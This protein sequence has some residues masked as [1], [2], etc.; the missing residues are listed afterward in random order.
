[1]GTEFRSQLGRVGIFGGTFDPIHN[2]H[3]EVASAALRTHCLGEIIFVPAR[4]QPHKDAR[5]KASA[6]HRLAMIGLAIGGTPAFSV[7]DCEL[8][9]PGK[10]FTI[11]TVRELGQQLGQATEIFF[12]VGSDSVSD[13]PAWRDVREL[14]NLCTLVV[15][16]RPGWPLDSLDALPHHLPAERVAAVKRAAIRSTS[17][18]VSATEVRRRVG[19]GRSIAGLVP[20]AVANYI[21]RNKLYRVT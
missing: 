11:D 4:R 14:S 18:A 16:A 13:L 9:R 3:L 10:S 2:G 7:S 15:A 21:A 20:D 5:P 6:E 1:M 12:I 17:S 8:K 19:S